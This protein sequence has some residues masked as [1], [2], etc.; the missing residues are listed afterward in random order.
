MSTDDLPVHILYVYL[1]GLW[2]FGLSTVSQV[3]KKD[4]EGSINTFYRLSW[5]SLEK[6]TTGRGFFITTLFMSSQV[7]KQ[8]GPRLLTTVLR[9]RKVLMTCTFL[10]IK[11]YIQL[12]DLT[13]SS[14]WNK[15]IVILLCLSN[16][17][18]CTN[19]LNVRRRNSKWNL[20]DYH[21]LFRIWRFIYYMD[22]NIRRKQNL[23]DFFYV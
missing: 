2:Q 10:L 12:N 7:H 4:R 5:V 15:K 13:K 23:T 22:I 3:F 17:R 11:H 14:V 6:G 18:S 21:L 16:W 1:Q 20:N 19:R 9:L 8:K